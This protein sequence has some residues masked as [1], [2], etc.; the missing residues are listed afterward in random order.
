[1][2]RNCSN[3]YHD[4]KEKINYQRKETTAEHIYSSLKLADYFIFEEEEFANLDILRIYD[5]LK[6]HDDIEII[7]EDT[8]ISDTENRIKK[9]TSELE[10]VPILVSKYPGK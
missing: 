6:Y 3:F 2:A 5:I 9:Q 1:V 10:A 4:S 7:T 8:C